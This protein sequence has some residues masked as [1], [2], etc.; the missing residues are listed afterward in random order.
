M[1]V[2]NGSSWDTVTDTTKTFYLANDQD[3]TNAQAAYD[4]YLSGNYPVIRI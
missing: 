2:Y 4:W 3:L 1:N